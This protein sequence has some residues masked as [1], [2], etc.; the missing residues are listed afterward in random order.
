MSLAQSAGQF[1]GLPMHQVVMGAAHLHDL[2]AAKAQGMRTAFVRRPNEWGP[3]G[4]QEGEPDDR[5]DVVAKD[6]VDL[7]RQLGA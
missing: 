2:Y 7:A 3:D 6:F 5:I 4:Q 1:L